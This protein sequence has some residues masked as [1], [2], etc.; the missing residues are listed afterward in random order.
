MQIGDKVK[1]RSFKVIDRWGE[2]VIILVVHKKHLYE[3]HIQTSMSGIH[4]VIIRYTGD[5]YLIELDT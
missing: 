3:Y 4:S 2:G 5:V 1:W